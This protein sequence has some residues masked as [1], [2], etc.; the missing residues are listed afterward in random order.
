MSKVRVVCG[1]DCPDMCSL[2]AEVEDGRI[3]RIQG[4]PEDPYTAG[5]ACAKVN[6]DM[7]TVHSPDRLR[8]PLRRTGPKGSG[9]FAPITWD[10]ALDE[11]TTRWKAIIAESGP[12][13]LLGY[14]YSAHQGQMNRRLVGG[15]FHALGAS[16]LQAG[17]VC[18]TCCETAWDLTLGPVGGTDP[19]S[20]VHSDLVIAW[21]CDLMAVNVHFW[22]LLEKVRRTGVKLVVIDPRRSQTAARA[23]WHLPIRIG[24]DAALAC[25][26]AHI[27]LRDGKLDRDYIAANTLGFDRWAAEVLPDFPPAR[28]A[29]ITGL[30]VE[31]VERLA[32]MYGAAKAS[33]IRLGEGMTRLARGG[34]ALRA[35]ATLPALTGA[36]G[37]EGGGALLLA[38]AS[39]DFRF[40]FVAKPSGPETSRMVN[41]LALG[42]ALEEMADPPIRGLFIAANNP[43]VT[44]PD[45]NRLRRALTREDLFTVVHD[46]FMTDT[47]RYADIV[48]PATTYLETEDFYRSYGSYRMQYAPAAVP[49]QH[50][51]RS[52]F[53]LAQELGQR[54]GLTDPAFTMA[55]KEIVPHFFRG[56]TG[57]I[58]DVDPAQ[59]FERT[60]KVKPPAAQDF[61]TPSGRLEIW[62]EALAQQGVP[63][64]PV[65]QEDA[66]EAADAARWPLRLL[67]AP[68]YFQA[69]TAYAASP[70]LRRREGAPCAILHPQDAARRGLADGQRV[71]L[72]NDRGAVGLVLKV[73]DEVQPGVVLVPGQRPDSE[74]VNGTVNMLCDE[75]RT[76]I[77]EGAC[78]QSTFLDIAPWTATEAA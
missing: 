37:R 45:V 30:P 64:M 33:L 2:L 31:D 68:G 36:Y 1:H 60:V 8:T 26:I 6:R 63:A 55:P 42:E 20:V 51:A 24:T 50:E 43:A 27:L 57:I 67:T 10:S 4:D 12:Q 46:P 15:L 7:E 18:D 69:H 70:F 76:D 72:F 74:A 11:I 53:R 16:R 44:N 65:W 5:F 9:Q 32:A 49:P 19:E 21:G 52:N 29:G 78:Y 38:A 41:H 14:A 61:R 48:L 25:G 34:Q 28:V 58:A 22:A 56:A 71:R 40:G 59:V 35:V 3:T 39:M 17:T 62:S 75:R 77:G 47:A 66:A 13:A 54:M 73:S 23:D